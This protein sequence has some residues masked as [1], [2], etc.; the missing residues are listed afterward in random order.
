[1]SPRQWALALQDSHVISRDAA[2]VA[3][4]EGRLRRLRLHESIEV[5]VT[6]FSCSCAALHW[7]ANLSLSQQRA[8]LLSVAL[9][10]ATRLV[11]ARRRSWKA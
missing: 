11:R 9:Q 4:L 6:I 1:M 3:R 5:G 2:P 7:A 8:G 10:R